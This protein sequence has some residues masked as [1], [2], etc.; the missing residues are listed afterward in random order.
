MFMD[1]IFNGEMWR[2]TNHKMSV[3]DVYDVSVFNFRTFLSDRSF[4]VAFFSI[5][6]K[7]LTSCQLALIVFGLFWIWMSAVR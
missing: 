1:F 4:C 3:V 7:L 6:S 2:T 5:T